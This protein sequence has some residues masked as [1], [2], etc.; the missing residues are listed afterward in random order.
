M[1]T[2]ISPKQV[3]SAIGVSE[4]SVKRWCDQGVLETVRTAG[5]HRRVLVPEVVRYLRAT[6]QPLVQPE[7]LGLPARVGQSELVLARALELFT[8]A[9]A[10][11]DFEACRQLVLGLYLAGHAAAE[12]GDALYAPAYRTIGERWEH[13]L[14]EVYEER[15]AVE[16]GL[17]VLDELLGLQPTPSND[18]PRAQGGTPEGDWYG[19]ANRLVELSLREQGWCVS[20]LGSSLPLTSL[21]A[22]VRANRPSLLWLCVSHLLDEQ[23]FVEQYALLYAVA[24]E[25]GAAIVLGG[26]GLTPA[27][28]GACRFTACCDSLSHL[29]GFCATWPRPVLAKS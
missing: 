17:R 7:I 25:C 22:A 16:I 5:G 9:L 12:L 26:R 21:V 8:E 1:R 13:G 11:G 15:R 3:A 2:A 18:A 4:S 27:V 24:V 28:K 19:L 20:S 6:G 10:R 14:A 23:A 29:V